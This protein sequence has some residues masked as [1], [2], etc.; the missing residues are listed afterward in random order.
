MRD[1]WEVDD[2]LWPEDPDLNPDLLRGCAYW[3]CDELFERKSVNHRF[4]R[5][6]CRSRQ[7]K[8]EKSVAR[9]AARRAARDAPTV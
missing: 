6:A 8:W 1:T 9:K 5:K 3:R 7:K 4:C 2:E